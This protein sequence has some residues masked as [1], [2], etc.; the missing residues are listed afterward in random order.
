MTDNKVLKTLEY[1]KILNSLSAKADSAPGKESALSLRPLTDLKT[2]D[3]LQKQ[4]QDASSRLIKNGNISFGFNTDIR[5]IAKTLEAGGSVSASDLLRIASQ[6]EGCGRVISFGETSLGGINDVLASAN[7]GTTH[8]VDRENGAVSE[9]EDKERDSDSLS[10]LFSSLSPIPEIS[11]E[12]RRCIVSEDEI[13]D[14]ASPELKSIRRKIAG[15]DERIHNALN[16]I[17]NGSVSKYLQDSV[18]TMRDGRYCIPVK[19]EYKSQV[20]GL[21]HDQSST[22]STYFI[23]PSSIVELNNEIR[24]LFMEEQKEIENILTDLSAKCGVHHLEILQNQSSLTELDSIFARGKLALEMNATRPMFN[25]KHYLILK[26]ARHPLIDPKKVVPIDVSLG[27]DFDLLVITGPNTGGKTVSLKT[28]GLLCLMGQS[29][30]HIPADAHSELCIFNDIF[31]DIG[32]EQSIEQSLSTFSSHMVNIVDILKKADRHSLCLFDELGAGTDPSEGAALAVSILDHLHENSIR[33]IATTHYTEI[34]IYALRTDKVE[35]ASCEF[36]VETLSPTYR[37]LIG[38]PGKS[39]AF[40]ISSKL[41][42]PSELI[43]KAKEYIS[44]DAETFEDVIS[45]LQ[46]S[47]NETERDRKEIAEY[48][49]RIRT[50]QDQL[51]NKNIKIDEQKAAILNRANDEAR[52]ILEDAKEFADKTIRNM[53]KAGIT[54]GM[55]ELEKDRTALREKINSLDEALSPGKEK[56]K[57][58]SQ[59]IGQKAVNLT[60]GTAVIIPALNMKGTVIS[61]PD[62]K[63]ELFVMCGSMR[64]QVKTADLRIDHNVIPEDDKPSHTSMGSVLLSKS[65]SV[66]PEINLLGMTTDEAV[67]AVSKYLDDAYVAHIS[68]VRI[69]HGK[70]TGALRSAVHSYLKKQKNIDSFRLGEYGEGD[71]GITIVNF[72]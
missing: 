69:V 71:A 19:A 44:S 41:G 2:I 18:V 30:L 59:E 4:T 13:A 16:K 20:P 7:A 42:L 70:G 23:E 28:V 31:A 9:T 6:L 67:S 46:E 40:A 33:T 61:E 66:S 24:T 47:R 1:D 58:K 72:K 22:G 34:K 29:G 3:L 68:P 15:S 53:Q 48:K 35:N 39:N 32:D 50:L 17:I 56:Q 65:M 5:I 60:K 27:R 37:L 43:E 51:H 12:I 25:R 57:K 54:S 62:S 52:Q 26:K 10:D 55:S 36:N 38:V 49:E 21:V 63:G 11:S 8:R 45:G 64:M 14:D